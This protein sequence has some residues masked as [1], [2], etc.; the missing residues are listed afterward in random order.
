MLIKQIQST[1]TTS[2]RFTNKMNNDKKIQRSTT[3]KYDRYPH[4]YKHSVKSIKKQTKPVI[5]LCFGC[6]TGEEPYTLITKYLSPDDFIYAIDTNQEAIKEAKQRN[7]HSQ[8]KYLTNIAEIPE[9]IGF[10]LITANSVLCRHPESTQT[11]CLKE[12]FPFS[13]FE[14]AVNKLDSHLKKNGIITIWNANYLFTDTK[15]SEKY[16]PIKIPNLDNS[17]FVQKFNSFCRKIEKNYEYSIFRK[18]E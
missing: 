13:L 11:D 18:L 3:T 9:H 7:S 12:I 2:I 16:A 1:S 17:G 5:V 4:L 15:I 6:S 8:I 10:D 14:E